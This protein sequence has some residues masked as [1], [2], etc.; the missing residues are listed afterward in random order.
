MRIVL[1]ALR[2]F[3]RAI[4]V[5]PGRVLHAS[6]ESKTTDGNCAEN[7]GAMIGVGIGLRRPRPPNRTGGFPAYGSPVGGFFIEA[8]SQLAKPCEARTARRSRSRRWAIADDRPDHC[9]RPGGVLACAALHEAVAGSSDR[10]RP[11]CSDGHA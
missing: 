5:I 2:Q 3:R 11:R 1:S 7:S 9:R 8:V 6:P 4:F 10:A